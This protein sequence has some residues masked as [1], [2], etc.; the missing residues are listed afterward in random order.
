MDQSGAAIPN[1][2]L[3]L[4]DQEK[5]Y[6]FEASSDSAGRYLFRSVAPGLY[7]VAVAVSG[8]EKNERKGIRM[9]VGENA[10]VDMSLKVAS[11]S[12]T[13]EVKSQNLQLQAQDAITG[14]VV[15][16]NFINDLPLVDRYVMDLTSLTPGVTEADVA[17]STRP[18]T[19]SGCLQA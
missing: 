7:T 2:K 19:R 5:G 3:A 16:R 9:D 13:V 17:S 4:I 10:T 8:F 12:E 15:D 1:A 11:S 6:R 18:L 14:L